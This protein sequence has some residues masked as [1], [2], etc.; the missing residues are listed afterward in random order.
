MRGI[1]LIN[2]G[3]PATC[4]KEAVKKFMGDMLS[5]PL[6]TGKPGWVSN[7]LAKKIIAPA[8]SGKSFNKYSQIWRKEHPE[9]SPMIYFMQKLAQSLE[10]KKNIPVEI[11]MRYGE[12]EIEQALKKLEKKSPLLHEVVVFPLYPHYTQSTTQ[13]TID[14][15]GRYFYKRPH[16]YRLRLVEHYF[17]HPAFINA[18]AKHAEPYLKDIDKLV[19]SYHSLPVDQVE[20][21]WKKGREFDYV[22]Q[23]KETNRL[24][25]EKL[26]IQLQYTLLLYASQRGNNWLKPFLDKDISDLPRLGWKKV[27]I[28]APGFPVDNLETLFDIDI[29]AR[30]LFMKAGGEKFVFV[31]SLNN[32][33]EWIEAIWKI[34][35]GV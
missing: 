15:I 18:L 28:I 11:A 20:A 25:C 4:S 6:V 7:F 30:E 16:S 8:S 2:I 23:L 5:D 21:G 29:E 10:E 3:T 1:L 31:P 14:E 12:P 22:Y 17:D 35:V 13:T 26:N 27:A 9:V 24:F 32:S 34:T 19:F 33:D